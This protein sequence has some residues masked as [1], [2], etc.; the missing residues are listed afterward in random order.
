[1]AAGN[2]TLKEAIEEAEKDQK[3]VDKKPDESTDKK[4]PDEKDTETSDKPEEDKKEDK[5]EEEI[6]QD[7]EIQTAVS[8]YRALRDPKQQVE[9]ITD[10]AVRLGIVKPN[11]TPTKK[12]QKTVLELLQETLGEEYPDLTKKFSTILSHIETS[13]KEEVNRLRLE[14]NQ[15]KQRQAQD[16][17]EVEFSKFLADNKLN[18]AQADAMIKEIE[19]L[20]PNPSAK[21]KITLTQYL[22]KIHKLV[23]AD[24]K[25]TERDVK[26]NEKRNQNLNDRADN[27]GSDVDESRL[28]SGSKRPSIREAIEA[29][30]QGITFD[31]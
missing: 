24:T 27:L 12:E 28:K 15:D 4:Q 26:K 16:Q 7:E 19:A 22:T 31:A 8:F 5:N 14:I 21:S 25:A 18:D 9:I 17:F 23:V 3:P 29:A 1:M 2:T 6:A 30:S 10:L 20:P 13:H 11:E